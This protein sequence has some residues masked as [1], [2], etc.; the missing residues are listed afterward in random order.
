MSSNDSSS[1]LGHPCDHTQAIKCFNSWTQFGLPITEI[2]GIILFLLTGLE[3]PDLYD[4]ATEALVEVAI[5]PD[6][7]K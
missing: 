1:P 3:D 7:D 4:K 6:S 5:H 2:L